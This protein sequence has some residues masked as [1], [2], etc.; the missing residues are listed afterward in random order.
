M[1]A[2]TGRIIAAVLNGA[3]GE[4]FCTKKIQSGLGYYVNIDGMCIAHLTEKVTVC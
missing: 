2:T 3:R 1:G 4:L